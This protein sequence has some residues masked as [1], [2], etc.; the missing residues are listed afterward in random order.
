L[1]RGKS[2]A[3]FVSGP[4]LICRNAGSAVA[5]GAERARS[6]APAANRLNNEQTSAIRSVLEDTMTSAAQ[7][8]LLTSGLF[9]LSFVAIFAIWYVE[10][11]RHGV[12]GQ[13][14]L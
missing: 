3:F 2:A 4:N 14:P 5:A 12:A 11:L 6:T 10:R 9:G 8:F 7:A 1:G 13:L